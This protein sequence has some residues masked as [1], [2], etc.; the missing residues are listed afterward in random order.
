MQ[1][2]AATP[3]KPTTGLNGPPNLG[4][5]LSFLS[6]CGLMTPPVAIA[7]S[8]V[9]QICYLTRGLGAKQKVS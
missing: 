8:F 2:A 4:G 3:L 1:L 9:Q 6:A 7:D 5:E